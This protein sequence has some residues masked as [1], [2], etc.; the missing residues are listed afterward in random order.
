MARGHDRRRVA[1]P[2]HAP[3]ID[4][5]LGQ[6]WID[7]DGAGGPLAPFL[8]WCDMENGGYTLLFNAYDSAGDDVPNTPAAL[9]QP[10]QQTGSGAWTATVTSVTHDVGA[11][12][13]SGF[14]ASVVKTLFDA[15]AATAL[16]A[17]LVSTTNTENCRSSHDATLTIE[18]APAGLVNTALLPYATANCTGTAGG[19][20]AAYTYGRISGLPGS[21][22]DF[23]YASFP[24]PGNCVRRG[25]GA[26]NDWGTDVT[27]L[28]E[29]N[30]TS[31]TW[32]GAWHGWGSGISFRPWDT[33]DSELANN[34]GANP[35][36]TSYALRLYVR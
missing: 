16:R 21:R 12:V 13:S 36:V 29:H 5:D 14:P 30:G 20:A 28:C 27:G 3:R 31:G 6:Y 9:A 4:A 7:L 18:T 11:T 2:A 23:A 33:A 19:C 8:T 32:Q 34:A 26:A 10:W 25:T 15:G 24:T 1:E 22:N 35:A 17:C